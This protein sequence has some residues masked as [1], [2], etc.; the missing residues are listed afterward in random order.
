MKAD[1]ESQLEVERI[2]YE[3]MVQDREQDKEYREKFKKDS[4]MSVAAD[5]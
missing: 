2:F 3:Q 4:M 1:K 5:R